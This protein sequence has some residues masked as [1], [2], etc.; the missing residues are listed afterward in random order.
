MTALAAP[1]RA[2]D[3]IESID[4]L[5]GFAL[6]GILLMNIQSYALV[7]AAY[8]DPSQYGDLT[9][10]NW[11][12]WAL[13]HAFADMKFM[14]LF[15]M[16]FGAGIVLVTQTRQAKCLPTLAHHYSRN[17]WLL[18][19]GLIH[20][21]LIWYGDILVTYALAA[22]VLYWLRNLR[23]LRLF[24]LGTVL[25]SIPLLINLS[26]TLAPP[27]VLKEVA[28][29][30]AYT[31]EEI[32]AELTA[33]RGSWS[34]AF[35]Y[36][37]PATLDMHLAALPG[38]LFWRA[39]GLM[40]I[41]MG[42]FKTGVLAGRCSARFYMKLAIA[43]L[44]VGLPL[45]TLS[46]LKLTEHGYDPLF[47]QLG[48]G[49]IYNYIGS[50]AIALAY[51]GVVMRLVQGKWLPGLQ[52]RLAAVGRT[53]FTNYIMQ[54]LICTFLF[55]GFGIGLFGYVQRWEQVLIVIA[56]WTLQIIIAPL[57]LARFRFGPL[58]WLWRSLTYMRLQP[59]RRKT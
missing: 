46:T 27:E 52:K 39:G 51:I 23:A 57:W 2:R 43:G 18:V 15:S 21:Y 13:S 5:R 33:Y 40:L 53:A 16:L 11:W 17:F 48:M 28:A 22:F 12:V 42:L 10:T 34:E 56:V 50:I 4:V 35:A 54:S 20:A 6:L 37:I 26:L 47:G 45:V 7:E 41:G 55:Y 38:F 24:I 3:R 49:I 8:F 59:M 9:G 36:R 29:D 19:F 1:V 25:L 44:A 31:M 58:E 30:F 14:A 32:T